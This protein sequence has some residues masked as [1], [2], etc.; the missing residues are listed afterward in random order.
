MSNHPA[1][2]VIGG[3]LELEVTSSRRYLVVGASIAS[4]SEGVLV[5]RRPVFTQFAASLRPLSHLLLLLL[6]VVLFS[7]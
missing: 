3:L 4:L 7:L 2:V 5:V 1:E 6:K